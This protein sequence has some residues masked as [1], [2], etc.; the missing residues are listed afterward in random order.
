MAIDAAVL[1]SRQSD[2]KK[3]SHSK[4]ILM[5]VFLAID[6]GL[7]STLDYDNYGLEADLSNWMPVLFGAQI[8]SQIASFLILFLAAADTFLFQVG[9]LGILYKEIVPALTLEVFY[10]LL[11]LL[12]GVVRNNIYWDGSTEVEL[13]NNN[14]FFGLAFAQKLVSIPYYVANLQAIARLEDP[15]YF[16][17]DAWISLVKQVRPPPCLLLCRPLSDPCCCC[18]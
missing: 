18:R 7:N 17:R 9:L 15:V 2:V 6:I 13:I 12:T 3:S 11:T 10:F 16:N 14:V 1:S 5:S 8:I 4:F